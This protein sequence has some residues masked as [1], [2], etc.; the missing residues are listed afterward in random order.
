MHNLQFFRF[1]LF[2][3]FPIML[4]LYVVHCYLYLTFIKI[5]N[6]SK[7]LK[8]VKKKKSSITS[9]TEL[10]LVLSMCNDTEIHH[11]EEICGTNSLCGYAHHASTRLNS[12]Y[13]AEY[14]PLKNKNSNWKTIL[15]RHTQTPT[16]PHTYIYIYTHTYI[17]KYSI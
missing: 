17:H 13:K 9:S 8:K 11:V 1:L 2:S 5:L 15:Y 4:S 14:L 16:H 6:L 7:T 10:F 12:R 3:A